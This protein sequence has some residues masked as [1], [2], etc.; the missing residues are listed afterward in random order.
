MSFSDTLRTT[1][2]KYNL[3][4]ES[5]GHILG[6]S[7]QSITKWETGE[8]Y[9]DV[10]NL[11]N[12]ATKL[13]VSLDKLFAEELKKSDHNTGILSLEADHLLEE[14][15]KNNINHGNNSKEK[16]LHEI[17][18]FT[19]TGE[20]IP[21]GIRLIDSID[22]GLKRGHIYVLAGPIQI[23]KTSLSLSIANYISKTGTVV[24]Y[25]FSDSAKYLYSLLLA[26]DSGI[27]TSRNTVNGYSNKK[28][29]HLKQSINHITRMDL[30]IKEFF[31]KS[32]ENIREDLSFYNNQLN[33][34]VIDSI[35]D[36]DRL[37]QKRAAQ[38]LSKIARDNNCPVLINDHTVAKEFSLDTKTKSDWI[39]KNGMAKLWIM[40]RKDYY[41][42]SY[43]R[44]DGYSICDFVIMDNELHAQKNGELKYHI[45]LC[46][47]T[48][49]DA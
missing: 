3:S 1:R 48:E 27:P 18:N 32:L 33:L 30:D 29:E 34:I 41:D 13:G 15:L 9:P 39:T 37:P 2:N 6:V 25:S 46:R 28:R 17:I 38:L 36:I 35:Y 42:I 12:L 21:T 16:I 49:I 47:F 22:G 7:R 40:N 20:I 4:Q 45:E 26:A 19:N 31:G 14:T 8:S 23:G 10:E 24:Y 43:R 44:N 5:L 11:L